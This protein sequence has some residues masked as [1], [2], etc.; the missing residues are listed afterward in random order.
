MATRYLRFKSRSSAEPQR[1]PLLEKLLARAGAPSLREDWR[2]DAFLALEPAGPIPGLAAAAYLTTRPSAAADIECAWRGLATPVHYLAEMSNVRLAADGIL[3]LRADE[4]ALLARD[5]ARIWEDSAFRLEAAGPLL[6]CSSRATVL[7]TQSDPERALGRYIQ[8][9]L[10]T[11]QDAPA[12][13]R[14]MS[15][16]E[17]WLFDHAVNVQ[18]RASALQTVSALWLWGGAAPLATLPATSA[19]AAGEDV[20]FSAFAAEKGRPENV[21]VVQDEPG[22]GTWNDAP[23]RWLQA[24]LEDLRRGVITRL[25]LSSGAWRFE[26]TRRWRSRIFRKAKPWWEYFD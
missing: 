21:M 8:E 23:A 15:E 26:V 16:M 20:F 6:F 13:K 4:A 18:R 12:L 9:F 22:A 2:A 14:L 11:G 5:F 3:Q 17:M 7:A 10:P 24:T 25:D 19:G 1:V